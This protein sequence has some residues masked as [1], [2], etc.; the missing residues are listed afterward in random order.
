M[1]FKTKASTKM[2]R[3]IV[4]N[5]MAPFAFEACQILGLPTGAEF[6]ARFPLRWVDDSID[7]NP[8]KQA[9]AEAIYC[10]RVWEEDR[11]IPLRR[12]KIRSAEVIG[13]ILFLRY[14]LAEILSLSQDATVRTEQ[15]R[16]FN[17][18]I[19]GHHVSLKDSRHTQN[20]SMAPLVFNVADNLLPTDLFARKGSSPNHS[21]NWMTAV[22]ILAELPDFD[23]F[24]FFKVDLLSP[25]G[26]RV[27]YHGGRAKLTSLQEYT[28]SIL[29][30]L[31]EANSTNS[32]G[33]AERKPNSEYVK[34]G[35]YSLGAV[36]DESEIDVSPTEVQLSGRYDQFRLKLKSFK[37]RSS[38]S[39]LKMTFTVPD[40]ILKSYSPVFDVPLS[41]TKPLSGL[42]LRGVTTLLLMVLFLVIT[43]AD[44]IQTA[45][46]GP[47]L[48]LFTQFNLVFFAL[49]CV[50]TVKYAREL[51][52]AR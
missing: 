28:A 14:E 2:I 6:R 30:R 5:S 26:N 24:P 44:D 47:W 45:L 27:D 20:D 10:L 41:F 23:G 1:G 11:I 7:Q 34:F 19:F 21:T 35:P 17:E 15:I 25:T 8:H 36:V 42:L 49:A 3:I 43:F 13:N 16:Q 40:S 4:A 9:D 37:M 29:Y 38:I 31:A 12:L 22:E 32:A 52:E 46:D 50:E 18:L 33:S 39:T 51:W 48:D